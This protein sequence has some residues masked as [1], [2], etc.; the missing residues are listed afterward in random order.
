MRKYKKNRAKKRSAYETYSYWYDK[1]TKGDKQYW[2]KDKLTIEEFDIT[3]NTFKRNK[4]K[5]PARTI[6]AQQIILDRDFLK[7]YKKKYGKDLTDIRTAEDREQIYIDWINEGGTRE[8]F[9]EYFY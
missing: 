1:Y 3:Y 8:T 4:I 5:N 9:E 7:K 6:A 2:F